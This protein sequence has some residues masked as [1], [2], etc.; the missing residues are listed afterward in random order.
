MAL[1]LNGTIVRWPNGTQGTVRQE[2]Y[3]L[4]SRGGDRYEFVAKLKI[5]RENHAPVT[6]QLHFTDEAWLRLP[7]RDDAEKS[8]AIGTVLKN[9][10]T[11]TGLQDGFFFRVDADDDGVQLLEL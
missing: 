11:R 9:R 6:G 5:E 1:D 7:G 2:E 8:Q 3:A 10:S 4:D